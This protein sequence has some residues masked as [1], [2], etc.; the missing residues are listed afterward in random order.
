MGK[1]LD[2]LS[3]SSKKELIVFSIVNQ[4]QESFI[5]PNLGE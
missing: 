1:Y 5:F 3:E 2:V 4:C